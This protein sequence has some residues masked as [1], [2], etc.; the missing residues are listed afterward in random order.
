MIST[1]SYG[2][3]TSKMADTE[4]KIYD[5]GVNAVDL[6]TNALECPVPITTHMRKWIL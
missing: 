4:K 2:E 3:G 6:S 5:R 1:D